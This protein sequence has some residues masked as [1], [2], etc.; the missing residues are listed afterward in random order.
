MTTNYNQFASGIEPATTSGIENQTNGGIDPANT[1]GLGH[2]FM[3]ISGCYS[4]RQWQSIMASVQVG[5]EQAEQQQQQIDIQMEKE[6]H[7]AQLNEL[8]LTYHEDQNNWLA[9]IKFWNRK[10]LPEAFE[11]M[12]MSKG[13][14]LRPVTKRDHLSA[15]VVDFPE[16]IV[17]DEAQIEYMNDQGEILVW[18][19]KT[20]Q[21]EAENPVEDEVEQAQASEAQGQSSSAQIEGPSETNPQYSPEQQ[22]E[23]IAQGTQKRKEYYE[24]DFLWECRVQ[25]W[26]RPYLPKRFTFY[27]TPTGVVMVPEAPHDHL[28]PVMIEIPSHFNKDHI[29]TEFFDNVGEIVLYLN[30]TAPPSN[31]AVNGQNEPPQEQQQPEVQNPDQGQNPPEE[32]QQKP[33]ESEKPAEEEE[34]PEEEEEK[35]DEEEEKPAEEEEN[36][37]E[38]EENPAEE[39]E[40]P[41]EEEEKPDEEEENPAEEGENPDNDNQNS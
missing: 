26:D 6:E 2:Q 34:K 15:V 9:N 4:P 18:V 33:E 19:E 38:E 39:E 40:N 29:R 17:S 16:H 12:N 22:D 23:R 37:A 20:S 11:I 28:M 7:E 27:T 14:A 36:P 8:K 1:S 32:N 24:D 35:P 21:S 30:K 41:A 5:I 25:F 13:L 3:L 10:Y 31:D